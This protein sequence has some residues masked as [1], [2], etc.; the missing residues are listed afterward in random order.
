MRHAAAVIVLAWACAQSSAR[1]FVLNVEPRR[2]TGL[3][4]RTA[5]AH[6]G[7][8]GAV[9]TYVLSAEAQVR[10]RVMN[11]AGKPI[12]TLTRNATAAAGSN[13]LM[14]NLASDLNTRVPNG[15]YLVQI[16][17]STQ[18]GQRASALQTIVVER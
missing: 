9:V 13:T 7:R 6:V 14:W 17:A 1:E 10:A 18:D 8:Q 5:G 11:I 3:T 2:S 15:C 16:E 4:V 12:R